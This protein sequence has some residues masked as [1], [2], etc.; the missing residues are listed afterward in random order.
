MQLTGRG[1]GLEWMRALSAAVGH[2]WSASW[3]ALLLVTARSASD[4]FQRGDNAKRLHS[5]LGYRPP[6]NSNPNSLSKRLSFDDPSGPIDGV[7]STLESDLVLQASTNRCPGQG[8][9][10]VSQSGRACGP[11]ARSRLV[12]SFVGDHWSKG[13]EII[14]LVDGNQHC[15]VKL[16]FLQFVDCQCPPTRTR[17]LLLS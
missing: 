2:C 14:G 6:T 12:R 17:H 9:V 1:H 16:T 11:R 13:Q 10:P 7:H 3:D 8:V 5:A 15:E 4:R